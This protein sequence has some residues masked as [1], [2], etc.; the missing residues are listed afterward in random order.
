MLF[1]FA[2]VL[3]FLLVG[4]GFVF[5]L[6]LIGRL[7]RPHVPL[8]EKLMRYECGELPTEGGRI[9]FNIRFYIFALVFII[10]DVEIALMFPVGTIFKRWVQEGRGLLA[11]SEIGIFIFILLLG[12]VYVWAKGDLEWVKKVGVEERNVGKEV[13][14]RASSIP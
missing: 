14:P 7:L 4:L 10:F 5:I 3:V 11:F 9:N 6:L 1:P 2:N 12:L 8:R 13:V